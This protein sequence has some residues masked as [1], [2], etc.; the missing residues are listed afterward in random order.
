M[1]SFGVVRRRHPI[2]RIKPHGS[3]PK[4]FGNFIL[5]IT[6]VICFNMIVLSSQS[7]RRQTKTT[8][9]IIKLDS[10]RGFKSKSD[11]EAH[12]ELES[13]PESNPESDLIPAE[14]VLN[15]GK[16]VVHDRDPEFRAE[17][18]GVISGYKEFYD[19]HE[20]PEIQTI[21]PSFYY[22]TTTPKGNDKKVDFPALSRG[23]NE[24]YAVIDD[25]SISGRGR[26]IWGSK[27]L[28]DEY[29]R[30]AMDNDN[31]SILKLSPG[32]Y[33]V[34]SGWLFGNFGHYVHDHVSKI[35]WLKSLV[36]DDTKFI[37]P[38][39]PIHEAVLTMVDK[40][41]VKNRVIWI[42]YAET[43]HAPEGSLTLMVPKSNAP[44]P[45]GSPQT[46]TIYTEY[47]RRWLEESHWS[48]KPVNKRAKNKGKVVFYSRAGSTT[49]RNVDMEL[50]Q[51]LLM[52]IREAM[53]KRG[54]SED[55]LT[56]FNG[57]DEDGN[58]LP[59]E[60]QFEIFSSA[61]TAIG[62]HGSGLT[63]MIWMDPRCDSESRP[64][65]LEFVSSERSKDVQVGS[66]WGYWFLFGSLPW[67]D[68]H[69]M[70]YTESSLDD[71]VFIDVI[72]FEETLNKLWGLNA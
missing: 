14:C 48:S 46:A 63:N 72:T 62:P 12:S 31:S 40:K 7:S 42:N 29:I 70:Y 64:K 28:E 68:Y 34:F 67:I 69:Q 22:Q 26:D 33:A 47:F 11:S 52:T 61:D 50:E 57:K 23:W 60:K 51:V 18:T 43:V 45:H 59:M 17:L 41:F 39:H 13:E 58:T 3:F 20:M 36:S 27:G 32:K 10:E 30:E 6:F 71:Q 21:E 38:F 1:R 44:F 54:Q 16:A 65:V 2:E 66:F 35:A 8:P 24:T 37:L 19:N 15:E 5:C 55:D 53:A 9:M 49:R 4:I 56:I 25:P